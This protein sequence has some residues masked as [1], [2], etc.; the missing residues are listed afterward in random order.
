MTATFK[1]SP[2]AM[3]RFADRIWNMLEESEKNQQ[4]SWV[5]PW[6]DIDC[7]YR[8]AMSNHKYKGL[9]N[10]LTCTLSP[11][12]DPRFI[13]FNQIRKAG[14]KLKK[15]SKATYLIAWKFSKLKND[16]SDP[17]SE[18]KI[19]PFAR[20]VTLF[21]VEQTEGLNLPPINVDV[22]DESISEDE[23][24]LDIFKKLKI[25]YKSVVGNS[26]H[27][28]PT[29]DVIEIPNV[30]QFK[31]TDAWGATCLHELVHWTARRVDR[32]SSK[33][34][35]DIESRAMEELV[36]EL[37]AMFLCMRLKINGEAE[38][39]S[40]SYI[41]SWKKATQG[42]NGKRF[43]YKACRLAEEACN[44]IL[45]GA[46]LVEDDEETDSQEK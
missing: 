32:D 44:F 27:Y 22:M 30:K 20:N 24:I 13:T 17:N 29:T 6:R 9:H 19:V 12:S 8:N 40:L 25:Q 34:N 43:V 3:Q 39:N 28:I 37:G 15:G 10:I 42:T 14:G 7:R 45:E 36:A 31:D 38:E 1:K 21:N 5:K 46:G 2:E 35:F 16:K 4:L 11:F 33:Y 41:S 26:A 18:E 23:R